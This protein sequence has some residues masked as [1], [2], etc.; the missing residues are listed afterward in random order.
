LRERLPTI[1]DHVEENYEKERYNE[2]L[3]NK[4]LGHS[5]FFFFFSNE[6]SLC[7]IMDQNSFLEEF[8]KRSKYVDI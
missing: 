7:K 3:K 4:A 6:N 1:V 5:F 8:N 2:F